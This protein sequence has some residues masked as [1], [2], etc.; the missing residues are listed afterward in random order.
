MLFLSVNPPERLVRLLEQYRDRLHNVGEDEYD[1]ELDY[2]KQILASPV[3]LD[4]LQ[5]QSTQE[6]TSK[7]SE[8]SNEVLSGIAGINMSEGRPISPTEKQKRKLARKQSLKAL[9]NAVTPHNSPVVKKKTYRSGNTST[10]GLENGSVPPGRTRAGVGGNPSANPKPGSRTRNEISPPKLLDSATSPNI[11]SHL[12]PG[13]GGELRGNTNLSNGLGPASNSLDARIRNL[14]NSTNTL[15]ERPSPPGDGHLE[16]SKPS[17]VP[18]LQ[19][20]FMSGSQPEIHRVGLGD[21]HA[22]KSGLRRLD[23]DAYGDHYHHPPAIASP[24]PNS[25]LGSGPNSSLFGPEWS[26]QYQHPSYSS[27]RMEH[28]LGLNLNQ[29]PNPLDSHPIQTQQ[30]QPPLYIPS[31]DLPQSQPPVRP[32]PPP[33]GQQLVPQRKV[34]S[35]E[36]LLDRPDVIPIHLPPPPPMKP[37]L[38]PMT[39]GLATQDLPTTQNRGRERTALVLEKGEEGLGFRVKGEGGGVFVQDLQPGGLAERYCDN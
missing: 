2:L 12:P 38:H 5:G 36:K 29:P 7:I 32:P 31:L 33:Y 27:D 37:L 15:I 35:F 14:S 9:R 3:F 30:N 28:G 25:D 8:F 4:Y 21:Q 19:N 6:D 17:D 10:E 22:P 13:T 20:G 39:D 24:G 34:K 16:K 18:L 1:E 11:H 26:H 23:L